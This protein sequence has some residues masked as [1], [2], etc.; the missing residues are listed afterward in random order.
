MNLLFLKINILRIIFLN[1]GILF[2][3]LSYLCFIYIIPGFEIC[4]SLCEFWWSWIIDF[5]KYIACFPVCISRNGLYQPFMIFG[6]I[7]I[8]CELILEVS[9]I[10]K[11]K[12]FPRSAK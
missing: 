7:S 2:L 1:L 12:N 6:G 3:V 9:N 10:I 8:I 5:P 4:G 11:K